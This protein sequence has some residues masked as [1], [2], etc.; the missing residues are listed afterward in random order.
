MK[1]GFTLVELLVTISIIGILSTLMIANFN[2]TRQR[3]RDAQ[4]KSDLRNIQTALRLYYNDCGEFPTDSSNT[5][6]NGCGSC[7]TPAACIWDGKTPFA[8]D[9]QTYMNI[10]PQ[11]PQYDSVSYSYDRDATDGDKYTLSACLENKSDDKCD[12]LVLCNAGNGCVY[13]ISP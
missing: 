6:I 13:S 7:D 3:A 4:R 5:I 11:D 1:K 9:N 2:S 12:P 10:L 8:T